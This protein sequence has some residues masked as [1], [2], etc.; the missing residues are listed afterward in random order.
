[1][2][3]FRARWREFAV[4]G[5]VNSALPF[6]LFCYAEQ[7]VTASIAAILNATSPFFGA[8]AAAIWLREPLTVRTIAGMGLG[9]AGVVVLV[10]WH[11]ETVT[12]DTALAIAACLAAALCYGLG[13]TTRNAGSRACRALP[14]PAEPIGRGRCACPALPFTTVTGPVSSLVRQC[15]RARHRVHRDRL[16]DLFQADRRPRPRAR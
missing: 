1:M 13:G 10:G 5:I 3:D 8:V 15:R 16:P 2:P 6:V 4:V 12:T 9:L 14:A 11:P 7:Y